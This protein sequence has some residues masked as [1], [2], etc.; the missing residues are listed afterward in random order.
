MDFTTFTAGKD[1]EGRRFDRVIKRIILSETISSPIY[2][3]MRKGLIKLNG[4]KGSEN[5]RVCAGDEIKIA[6]FLLAG[7]SSTPNEQRES[8]E[9]ANAEKKKFLEEHTILKTADFLII[10]KPYDISVQ[11]GKENLCDIVSSVYNNAREAAANTSLSFRA[12]ALHRLDRKTTGIQV[13]SQSLEGAKWFSQAIKTHII[14][15]TYIAIAQGKLEKSEK[16]IDFI[17]D[18]EEEEQKKPFKLKETDAVWQYSTRVMGQTI[19]NRLGVSDEAAEPEDAAP[20]QEP[21]EAG[22]SEDPPVEDDKPKAPVIGMD[23]KTEDGSV[24]Y[25]I[26]KDKLEWMR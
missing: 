20:P 13:F 15:K 19:L 7:Q 26:L 2:K 10:N 21:A 25:E 18:S 24:P 9:R 17:D 16:W 12:G 4:K 11:G 22:L 3:A 23:G 8:E 14:K 1:D 5:D 6:S